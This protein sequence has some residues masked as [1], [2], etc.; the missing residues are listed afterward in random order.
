MKIGN[1]AG[2]GVGTYG[3]TDPGAAGSRSKEAVNN[4]LIANQFE[5]ILRAR[6]VEVLNIGGYSGYPLVKRPGVANSAGVNAG[7][8]WHCNASDFNNVRGLSLHVQTPECR[9]HALA[10]KIEAHL[11]PILQKWGVPY[12]GIVI[13]NLEMTRETNAPWVLI[14]DGFITNDTDQDLEMN[15]RY[16]NDIASTVADGV[17][18]YLGISVSP[19]PT[20]QPAPQPAPAP[21]PRQ[22]KLNLTRRIKEG[23]KGE[24][25]KRVQA[26]LIELGYPCGKWGTDGV[27]GNDTTNAILHYQHDHGLP[28]DSEVWPGYPTQKALE[29]GRR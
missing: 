28:V 16:V 26:R 24:D 18:E 29:E 9:G 8:S 25:V 2:H 27:D 23:C 11:L 5:A 7:I 20:P 1:D 4:Q 14:E 22:I 10:Q 21:G 3:G 13:Q 17:M 12:R 6:G 19:T 15:P